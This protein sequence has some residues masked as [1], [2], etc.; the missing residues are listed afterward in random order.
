MDKVQEIRNL[1]RPVLTMVVAIGYYGILF[2]A[3]WNKMITGK[4][5]LAAASG[6][7][8]MLMTYHF[9]K[10]SKKDSS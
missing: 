5:A 8:L 2:I 3:T 6:P 1:V 7:F 9:A 10:A 4:E